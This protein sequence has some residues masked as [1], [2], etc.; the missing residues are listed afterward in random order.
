MFSFFVANVKM[1]YYTTNY[2]VFF[3]ILVGSNLLI[4][5]SLLHTSVIL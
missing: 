1:N 4:V 3:N 5:I 2:L